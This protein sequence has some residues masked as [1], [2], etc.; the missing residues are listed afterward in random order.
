MTSVPLAP[1]RGRAE[2]D[3]V[4]EVVDRDLALGGVEV[5]VLDH[6][7]RVVDRERRVHQ[8]H[9]VVGGGGGHDPPAGAGGED[10]GGVHQVLGA[11]AGAHGDLRP[12]HERHRVAAAEHVPGLADLV[13]HLVGRDPQEVGVHELDD[14]AEPAVEGQPAAQPGERVLAD[15]RAEHAA[16]IL[17]GQALG[18]AVGAPVE[19]VHV[20]AEHDDARVLAH[21]PV[22]DPGHGVDELAGLELAG[23]VPLLDRAGPGEFGQVAA[24]ADVDEGGVG[25]QA[26]TD[27]AGAGLAVRDPARPARRRPASWPAAPAPARTRRRPRR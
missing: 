24:D 9:V 21:P 5:D 19:P 12:Q 17:L 1:H 10:A 2:G 4:V 14:R 22:H 15:R 13:E 23:E 8:A 11:V 6:D 20:L 3:L 27:P 16:G 18:G 26:G 25:P 7:H